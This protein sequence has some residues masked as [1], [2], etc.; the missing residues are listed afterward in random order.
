MTNTSFTVL[1]D[2]PFTVLLDNTF[3]DI[4][5]FKSTAKIQGLSHTIVEGLLT[6]NR[7]ISD[8]IVSL[9]VNS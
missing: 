8:V 5:D 2:I 1:V 3:I 4:S 6:P 7:G 9:L